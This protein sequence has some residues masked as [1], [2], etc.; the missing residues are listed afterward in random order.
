MAP[1]LPFVSRARVEECH[2]RRA[3]GDASA[4][5][6]V[7]IISR[8]LSSS[9]GVPPAGDRKSTASARKPSSAI[10][11]RHVLDVRVEAAVLVHDDDG[12]EFLPLPRLGEIALEPRRAARDVDHLGNEAR[13]A[14]RDGLGP[15]V[16]VLE[17][18]QQ[19]GCGGG[20]AGER[21]ET[22]EEGAAGQA[23]MGVA[24]EQLD[25]ALVHGPL[26]DARQ[27]FT[28]TA[29]GGVHPLP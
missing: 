8:A 2:G 9:A 18:R 16:V 7:P 27:G 22:V 15:G 11:A 1:T 24:I 3:I 29:A 12:G 5:S 6:S 26:P 23:A 17:Q 25:D 21:G 4:G 13:I 14:L 28:S 20:P 19:R 10:A